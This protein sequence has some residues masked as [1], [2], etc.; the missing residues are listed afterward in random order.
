MEIRVKSNEHS[1]GKKLSEKSE[2]WS[3]IE[4]LVGRMVENNGVN[5]DRIF[6]D[7]DLKSF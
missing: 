2:V 4:Q 3:L 6:P 5:E 7:V 1:D